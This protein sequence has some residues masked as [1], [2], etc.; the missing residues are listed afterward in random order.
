MFNNKNNQYPDSDLFIH[1]DERDKLKHSADDV[2]FNTLDLTWMKS[3][4]PANGDYSR[5]ISKLPVESAEDDGQVTYIYNKSGFRSDEFT[6]EHNGEPH[7]LFMGCSETEGYGANDGEFWSS[8][9]HKRLTRET[10]GF[11]NLARGGWGWEKII[12]NST[13]YF[14]KYGVPEYMFILLPNISRYWQYFKTDGHWSYIQRYVNDNG[15]R[16]SERKIEMIEYKEKHPFDRSIYL[17]EFVRFIAGW[18]LY[19]RYCESLGIKVIWSTWLGSDAENIMSMYDFKNFVY[20]G[21]EKEMYKL[22]A[23]LAAD[24]KSDGTYK[25]NDL[26]RR[27]GH[28]GTIYHQIWADRFMQKAIE[29]GWDIV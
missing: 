8:I 28:H 6:S 9:I 4:Q 22:T 11:F 7:V 24:K 15:P 2:F 27:D 23:K 20:M 14:E 16:M 5:I 29:L 13:I 26:R 3:E 19:L 17:S 10:S 25:D 21:E 1:D 18:K 12:A